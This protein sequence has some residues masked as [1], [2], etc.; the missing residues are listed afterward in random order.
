[1]VPLVC[2]LN[3]VVT[4]LN[5]W[6]LGWN[7]PYKWSEIPPLTLL[8]QLTWQRSTHQFELMYFL[9]KKRWFSNPGCSR[10]GIFYLHEN[11]PF[12]TQFCHGKAR[13][14]APLSG[15]GNAQVA[16]A[17]EPSSP[18]SPGSLPV[19]LVTGLRELR[20]ST[21]SRPWKFD[22]PKHSMYGILRLPIYS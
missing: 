22:R 14:K 15:P 12:P 5:K 1:M 2:V 8:Q 9:L 18:S 7:N 17:T 19:E 13:R 16:E 3:G 20:P 21:P 4:T 11:P 6:R 10:N